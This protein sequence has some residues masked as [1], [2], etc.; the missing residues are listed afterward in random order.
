AGVES[1]RSEQRAAAGSL[2]ATYATRLFIAGLD[3]PYTLWYSLQTLANSPMQFSSLLTLTTDPDGGPI[4]ALARMDANL[5]IFKSN[6]IFYITGQGPTPTG[7]SNDLGVPIAIPS[8][9]VGC[10]SQNSIVLTPVGLLFQS[11]NG[12]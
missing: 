2:I 5:L 11:S 3:D 12:I 1:H 8:G 7:D 9:E 6:A 10:I 4:T